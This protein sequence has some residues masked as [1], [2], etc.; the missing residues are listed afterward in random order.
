LFPRSLQ[1]LHQEEAGSG[2][3]VRIEDGVEGVDPFG[4][5][6]RVGIG[7]LVRKAVEDHFSI[8]APAGPVTAQ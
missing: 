5:L 4:C 8:V 1:Q 6:A 2:L 7:E 3:P